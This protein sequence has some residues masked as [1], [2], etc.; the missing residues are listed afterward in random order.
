VQF[1]WMGQPGSEDTSHLLRE[2]EYDV[3]DTGSHA[4]GGRARCGRKPGNA[5]NV[6]VSVTNPTPDAQPP[7]VPT[8]LA[9][10]A[11]SASSISPRVASSDNVE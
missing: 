7:T 11:V 5:S 3:Y 8:D 10:S 2:L 4:F 6:S 9:V 1:R